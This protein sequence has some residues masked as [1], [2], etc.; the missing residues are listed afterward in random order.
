M[1]YT[2]CPY[3]VDSKL[4]FDRTHNCLYCLGCE[5]VTPAQASSTGSS[6]GRTSRRRKRPSLKTPRRQSAR[7]RTLVH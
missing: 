4:E 1:G 7:T 5:Y 3:C 2:Y 6:D